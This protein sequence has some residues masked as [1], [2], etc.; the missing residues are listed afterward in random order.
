MLVDRSDAGQRLA[1]L[2]Q[3]F[4]GPDVVVL[5]LPR[6]GVPVAAEV[7]R[8]L[9]APLDVVVVRKLGAPGHAELAM[10]AV[11]EGGAVVRN[12]SVLRHLRVEEEVFE[13]VR[14]REQAEVERRATALRGGRPAVP[15][16]GRTAVL[17][18]DGA[19]TGASALVAAEVVRAAGARR[20]V[21]GV[22]VA[23]QDAVARLRE[24][25]DEVVVVEQPEVF[26]A[27]GE[28]YGDFR[29]TTEQEVVRLL[30]GA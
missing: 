21:L 28:H 1:V 12:A 25:A 5:G 16:A 3:H 29:Q 30:A 4:A 7:A 18:D 20:V 27:V 11:G 15:V 24:V 8:A 19:A 26:R 14:L 23:P 6:G 22:P 17:V 2:L 9:P 10:G 13:Q